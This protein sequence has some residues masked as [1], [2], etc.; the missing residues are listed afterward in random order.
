MNTERISEPN[1]TLFEPI[2]D[3][4]EEN[5]LAETAYTDLLISN[6]ITSA[7]KDNLSTKINKASC[8]ANPT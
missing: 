7:K 6:F 2:S 1:G 8:L 3:R 5:L 4:F